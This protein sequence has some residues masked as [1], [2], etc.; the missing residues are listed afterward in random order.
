MYRLRDYFIAEVEKID[1]VSVNGHK[2]HSNAPH[3]VSVS[4]SGV[5]S[6]VLL[7][8]LED[9]EIYV[10]ARKRMFFQQAGGQQDFAVDRIE[11]RVVGVYG[12]VQFFRT[13]D[14]GRN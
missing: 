13:H 1:G 6:E 11:T 14:K 8:A 4:V 12:T 5:R 3:I 7:H 2:D 10:S 9:R